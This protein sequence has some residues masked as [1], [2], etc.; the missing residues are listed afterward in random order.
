VLHHERTYLAGIE[1]ERRSAARRR[2]PPADLGELERTLRSGTFEGTGWS[3]LVERFGARIRAVALAHRLSADDADDV[4]QTTWL[5]LLEHA[6]TIREPAA[7][8][9]W[10]HTTARRESLAVIRSAKREAPTD[11]Q[12]GTNEAAASDPERDAILAEQ[13]AA[14]AA[15]VDRLPPRQ[16]SV[17]ALMLAEPPAGYAQIARA[18]GVPPGSIGPTRVRALANLRRDPKLVRSLAG[19][20]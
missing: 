15:G 6:G 3:A 17:L 8:G 11:E 4:C 7:L 10:L 9:M 1:A 14:L 12:L 5:R 18:L 16:R 19:E 2:R 13:R 20:R